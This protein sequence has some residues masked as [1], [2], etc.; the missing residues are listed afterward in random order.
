MKLRFI[1]LFSIAALALAQPPQGSI[2][3]IAVGGGGTVATP[4]DYPPDTV[5]AKLNGRN[6]TV[7]EMRRTLIGLPPQLVA[8]VQKDPKGVLQYLF[9]VERLAEE[10]LKEH[11]DQMA[12]TKEQLEFQR[13]SMLAQAEVAYRTNAIRIPTEELEQFY[14]DNKARWDVAHTRV[15]YISFVEDPSKAPK[16]DGKKKI[17]SEAEAKAKSEDLVKQ[18]RAGADF[19]KFA[20]EY[21]EDEVSRARDGEYATISRTEN[22][23]PS[24]IAT[25]F[26]LKE[27][28]ISDPVRQPNGFYIFKLDSLESKP[29]AEVQEKIFQEVKQKKFNEWFEGLRKQYEVKVEVEDFFKQ[30]QP[31]LQAPVETKGNKK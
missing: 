18:L 1:P 15:I 10:A 13:R 14:Q 7:E 23:P 2:P 19:K 21:S 3:N 26:S 11:V 29:Y 20:R 5:V 9:L 22:L 31:Y 28:D 6:I 17:L 24:I 25:V 12:P 4:K 30:A 27:G 8:S 16:G